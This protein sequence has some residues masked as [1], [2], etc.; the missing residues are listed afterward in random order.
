[1]YLMK[2]YSINFMKLI[3]LVV[4]TNKTNQSGSYDDSN[5]ISYLNVANIQ[6]ATMRVARESPYPTLETDLT[7]GMY[8]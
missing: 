6:K 5:K 2:V 4:I 3:S 8:S 1:M 7:R